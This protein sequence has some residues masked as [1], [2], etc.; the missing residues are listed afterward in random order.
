MNGVIYVTEEEFLLLALLAI[1]RSNDRI[2]KEK[3]RIL[4]RRKQRLNSLLS[5]DKRSVN[6]VSKRVGRRKSNSKNKSKLT[7]FVLPPSPSRMQL[8]EGTNAG[9]TSFVLPPSP[10]RMQL[11]EGTNAGTTSFVLPPSPSR[12]QLNGGTN[13]G[14]TSF[15][16]PPSPSRMQLNGGTNTGTTSFVLPPSPSKTPE[17]Q[18]PEIAPVGS[19]TF[20]S[21]APSDITDI[22]LPSLPSSPVILPPSPSRNNIPSMLGVNIPQLSATASSPTT[23]LP[24]TSSITINESPRL[25]SGS[26]VPVPVLSS[27]INIKLPASP[28]SLPVLSSSPSSLPVLSSLPSLR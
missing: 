10:S 27:P 24:T 17:I 2:E 7:T 22:K 15:V 20:A 3:D 26:V 8:N 9:T 5:E 21:L 13:T 28:S 16:L 25:K 23:S 19:L 6:T 11:N 4:Q 18:Y 1:K 12:M 14:T